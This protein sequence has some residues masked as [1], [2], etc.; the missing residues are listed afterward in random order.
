MK[1]KNMSEP[2]EVFRGQRFTFVETLRGEIPHG[3][4]GIREELRPSTAVPEVSE[5]YPF[6]LD[7]DGNEYG[8]Y[9]SDNVDVA[10]GIYSN[11]NDYAFQLDLEP[12]KVS[13][14]RPM[15][16]GFL[17]PAVG[18]IY[19]V[20]PKK[21]ENFRQ[22]VLLKTRENDGKSGHEYIADRVPG[23]SYDI[24]RANIGHDALARNEEFFREN[25]S[26]M[27][28]MIAAVSGAMEKRLAARREAAR[29][30]ADI[31]D[32]FDGQFNTVK[33]ALA[34]EKHIIE[35]FREY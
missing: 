2:N 1:N 23:D 12:D 30:K 27:P 35:N 16:R 11:A 7:K 8:V 31:A 24:L 28:S 18:V 17:M 9:M 3:G 5:E 15:L 10:A 13:R 20:D 14:N 32:N 4:S 19:K 34:A 6:L 21:T 22:P 29:Q 33:A 26:D 25:F